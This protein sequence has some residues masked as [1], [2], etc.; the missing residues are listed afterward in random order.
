MRYFFSLLLLTFFS[1]TVSAQSG[2]KITAHIKGLQDSTCYL[3]YYTGLGN[4]QFFVQ[5]TAQADAQGNITFTGT[6]KLPEGLY[7]ISISQ[8]RLF[9]VIVDADQQFELFTDKESVAGG[10]PPKNM[11]VSG[12]MENELF[13]Q[14]NNQMKTQMTAL[15]QL[16]TQAQTDPSAADKMKVIQK[17][18][19]EYRKKFIREHAGSFTAQLFK[20]AGEPEVPAA[21]KLPN[22][23]VDST[24]AYRYYKKHYFDGVDLTDERLLRTP[25]LQQKL[26]YYFDNLVHQLPDSLIK[27]ADFL[28]SRAKGNEMRRYVAFRITSKYEQSRVLGTEALFV[29]MGEKYYVGEPVLWDS[30]TVTNFKNRIKILKPLLTGNKIPNMYQTDT[31]GKPLNLYDVKANYTVLLI[32][33]DDCSH[34]RESTPGLKKFYE[35]YKSKGVKIYATD[36]RR[37]VT[38][39][40]KFIHEFKTQDFINVID[41]HKDAQGKTVHYTDYLNTFDAQATPTI[42]VLDKD[43]KILARRFPAEELDKYFEFLLSQPAKK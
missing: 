11:K 10:N 27:E 15:Q 31:L 17:D 14:M 36:L 32:Y 16:R 35:K 26:D 20:A 40:K 29:H 23:K 25:F 38:E 5:D 4:G 13:Y 33:S 12:S 6:K 22:G 42:Y 30:S 8:W 39:W 43:K 9:D 1:Y 41:V 19:L 7:V 18:L 28:M 34:C 3:A 24:F 2:Y 21:P 37:D